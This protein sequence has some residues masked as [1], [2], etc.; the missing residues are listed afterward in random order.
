M[1]GE[2]FIDHSNSPLHPLKRNGKKERTRS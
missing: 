2:A 1:R